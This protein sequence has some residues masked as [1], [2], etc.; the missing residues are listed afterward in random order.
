MSPLVGNHDKGR[1]MA[2]ADGDLPDPKIDKEEEVGWG[3]P[4]KVDDADNYKKLELAHAFLMAIDG[5]PMI[6]YGDEFGMTGAGDP[7]NRRDMRFGDQLSPDE[8]RVLDN[9]KK[10]TAI[11]KAHPA[12]RYGSRRTVQSDHDVY[13]FVRAYLNDRVAVIF[14]RGK[15]EAKIAIDVSPELA[16]GAYADALHATDA[17]IR[18]GKLEVTVPAESAIFVV[19]K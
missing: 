1:F 9:F 13:A 17:S 8:Q 6:Y 19:K 3:K 4:P 5:V 15:N 7:D 10:V 12:L 2:Y 14:N 11:R 16:D 18:D